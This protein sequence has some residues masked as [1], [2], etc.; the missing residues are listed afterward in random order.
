MRLQGG[1]DRQHH[2]LRAADEGLV[3]ARDIDPAGEQRGA[4]RA[5]EAAREQLDVRRPALQDM[6]QVEPPEMGVLQVLQLLAEHDRGGRAVGA[7]QG[8][9]GLAL[10]GQHRLDDAEQGG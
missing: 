9:I 4:F 6:D 3:G 2:R 10:L 5:I 8:E 7:D 1:G